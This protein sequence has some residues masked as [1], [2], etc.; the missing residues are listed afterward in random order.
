MDLTERDK[1]NI[2]I[3]VSLILDEQQPCNPLDDCLRYANNVMY[4]LR[5]LYVDDSEVIH[6]LVTMLITSL[7]REHLSNILS[8]GEDS[9]SAWFFFVK[10]RITW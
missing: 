10:R 9:D 1:E 2:D 5:N 8:G 4:A 3:T 7:Y 6:R